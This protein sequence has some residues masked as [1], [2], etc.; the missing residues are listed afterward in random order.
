MRNFPRN[1]GKERVGWWQ[2]QPQ[3]SFCRVLVLFKLMSIGII[4]WSGET[5]GPL[6]ASLFGNEETRK[7]IMI[8]TKDLYMLIFFF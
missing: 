7:L 2:T 8:I 3:T 6:L 1:E 4:M 5:F